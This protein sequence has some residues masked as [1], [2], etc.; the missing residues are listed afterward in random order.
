MIIVVAITIS[1]IIGIVHKAISMASK[2]N[3]HQSRQ[4]N[5]NLWIKFH[6]KKH[7]SITPSIVISNKIIYSIGECNFIAWFLVL[8]VGVSGVIYSCIVDYSESIFINSKYTGKTTEIPRNHT[9]D[10]N[11][12]LA[13]YLN[14]FQLHFIRPHRRF[15]FLINLLHEY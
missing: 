6:W 14:D 5:S 10:K 3:T 2:S 8:F 12:S 15:S 1:I 7:S 13:R 11:K 9:K 4:H